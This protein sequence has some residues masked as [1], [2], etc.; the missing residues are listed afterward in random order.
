MLFLEQTQGFAPE[1]GA[2]DAAASAPSLFEL[3]MQERMAAGFKPAVEYLAHTL[4]DSYPNLA[5]TLPVRRLDESY[6]LLRLCLEYYFLSTHGS[7]ATEKFYGM[8][9]VTLVA[10]GNGEIT[11]APL[12]PRARKLALLFAVVVPYLKTKLDAYHKETAEQLT[13]TR[14]STSAEA[15]RE[16][17][18]G[19][20]LRRLRSCQC[21]RVLKKGF[22]A[23]YPFAHFAY[24]GSFFLYHW[25]YLF[26]DTPYFSPF[27][28][29]MKTSLV[30]VTPDDESVFRQNEAAYREKVLEKVAGPGLFDRV[31][32]LALR[33]TWATLDH[34]YVLLLLGVAGYKFVEWMYSEEGEAAKLRLTG[35][36]A[37]IPPPPLP[38]H[39]SGQ[40]LTLAT[41]DPALCPL[42]KKKRVNPATIPSGYVFCYMCIYHHLE[43]HGE[44]PITQ[45]KCEPTSII[46]IYDDARDP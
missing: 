10:N 7:L 46:K 2:P 28:R 42:C 23:T 6:A 13:R 36:D 11:T 25:L 12:T 15:A 20:F 29:F 35:T 40:A 14:S 22:V 4:C 39:F 33:A 32:R 26:G 30:R 24:E 16:Q 34:S 44:C 8:K 17:R 38:P 1:D 18:M 31:R 21:L 27:L 41:M 45:I 3:L 37:P 19:D 5:L 9:R 43:K